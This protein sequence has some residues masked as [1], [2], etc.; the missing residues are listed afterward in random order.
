VKAS[1]GLDRR[2]FLKSSLAFS[3]AAPLI[4]S[5]SAWATGNQRPGNR[6]NVG[7][8]GLGQIGYAAHLKKLVSMPDVQIVALCDLDAAHLRPAREEVEATY[9]SRTFAGSYRGCAGYRD[10]RE[11]IVRE[12]IDAVFVATPD[13][14]HALIGLAAMRAGKDVYGEKPLGLTVAEGRALVQAVQRYGRVFQIG[15]QLRSHSLVKRLCELV[16]N[17]AIGKV[18]HATVGLPEGGHI[19]PQPTMPV[20]EGFDYDL[21]LGPAPVAPYTRMRCHNTFR[22]ILDYSGGPLTDLGTHYLDVM[23]WAMGLDL[24]GPVEIEGQGHFDRAGLSDVALSH[25]FTLKYANGFVADCSTDHPWGVRWEGE[26]GWIYV[27]LGGPGPETSPKTQVPAFSDPS[28]LQT[29][30][31]DT[32]LRF[33][34]STDHH[35][36]FIDCVRTRARPAAPIESG[37]RAT[38]TC[39]LANIAMRLGRRVQWDPERELFQGDESANQMLSR[40]MREP[41]SLG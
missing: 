33:H 25:R 35:Q 16:R 3:A 29:T 8:V 12:D 27:P 21:W 9:A 1:P 30:L 36:T 15:T 22:L 5:P 2:S 19:P 37:H 34:P 4:L 39:H 26:N 6:I 20:P 31:P 40:A 14:W 13:H 38:S 17:G 7:I 24:T 32:A 28:I 10:F 23:Q 41:W 11:M 18:S